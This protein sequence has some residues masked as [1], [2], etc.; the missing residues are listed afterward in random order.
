MTTTDTGSPAAT[1]P[2]A[3]FW[4]PGPIAAP[5]EPVVRATGTRRWMLA[6]ACAAGSVFLALQWGRNIEHVHRIAAGL[7]PQA[8]S[9][10]DL[11][12]RNLIYCAAAVI[13]VACVRMATNS[14]TAGLRPILGTTTRYALAYYLRVVCPVATVAGPLLALVGAVVPGLG[15]LMFGERARSR[16]WLLDVQ[17]AMAAG[18]VES[19]VALMLVWVVLEHLP[20]GRGR[21]VADTAWAPAIVVVVQVSYH[22][23][24]GPTALFLVAPV[25]L[26]VAGWRYHRNLAGIVVGHT[27]YDLVAAFTLP[28][29]TA[30]GL[31]GLPS[32][33]IVFVIMPL[34]FA[35][36]GTALD[37][38]W[39][40]R[41]PGR[42]H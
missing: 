32:A 42:G 21:T 23:D 33:V 24:A 41:R 14:H 36:T 29:L 2:V 3:T 26:T 10:A 1:P 34:F 39:L 16:P 5:D 30:A 12:T 15:A 38:R 7:P 9:D 28:V 37:P 35:I 20:A 22:L 6:A 18:L 25:L 11:A 19:V 13:T 31:G 8:A 17:H 27:L 40:L 4:R